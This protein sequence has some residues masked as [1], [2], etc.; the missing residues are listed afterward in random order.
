M[1]EWVSTQTEDEILAAIKAIARDELELIRE[2]KLGDNL[3]LD[4]QLDSMSI[5]VLAVAL[6]DHF[7]VKLTG[8]EGERVAT[9]GDLVLLIAAQSGGG[10]R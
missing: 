3:R 2:V 5:T 6:E 9:V 10:A 7:R 4:L 1:G 8:P